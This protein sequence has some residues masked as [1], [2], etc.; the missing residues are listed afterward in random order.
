LKIILIGAA[1]LSLAATAAVAQERSY[2]DAW[3]SNGQ[4]GQDRHDGDSRDGGQYGQRQ[5]WGREQSEGYHWRRGQRM[6]Y[7]NWNNARPVD[8]REHHLRR[9]ARGYE[10]R[11]SNGQYVLGAVATGLIIS[12]IYNSGR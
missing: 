3:R 11:E 9:P 12:T 5:G 7:D 8:Y 4:Q 1:I 10:W 2:S 6:G